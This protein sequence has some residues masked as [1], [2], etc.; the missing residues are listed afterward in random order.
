[1]LRSTGLR[2]SVWH[3]APMTERTCNV[4]FLCTGDDTAL[5][6]HLLDEP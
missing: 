4:L 5:K 2:G 3:G 1:M 6:E